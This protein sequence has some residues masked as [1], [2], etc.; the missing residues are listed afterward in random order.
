MQYPDPKNTED[1]EAFEIIRAL[2]DPLLVPATK[3]GLHTLVQL[4]ELFPLEEGEE[5]HTIIYIPRR[6]FFQLALNV[7]GK[8]WKFSFP[9][10]DPK[11]AW[12]YADEPDPDDMRP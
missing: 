8:C 12:K 9:W 1:R 3:P 2:V 6:Q 10:V 5:P 11:D 7:K 4:N